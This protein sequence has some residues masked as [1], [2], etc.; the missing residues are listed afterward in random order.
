MTV[1]DTPLEVYYSPDSDAPKRG[2]SDICLND[3]LYLTGEI[4]PVY[5]KV[6]GWIVNG[7]MKYERLGWVQDRRE[8]ALEIVLDMRVHYE[9]QSFAMMRKRHAYAN[10]FQYFY[11]RLSDLIGK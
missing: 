2:E 4:L 1:L 3:G 11:R 7:R 10:S 5:R 8:R 9:T 6:S